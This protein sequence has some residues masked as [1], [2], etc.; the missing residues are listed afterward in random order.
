MSGG[1]QP[2]AGAQG[3]G[4]QAGQGQDQDLGEHQED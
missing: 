4:G 2:A 1:E 3:H